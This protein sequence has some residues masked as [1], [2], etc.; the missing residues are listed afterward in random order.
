MGSL[1]AG[2]VQTAWALPQVGRSATKCSRRS[3]KHGLGPLVQKR[4]YI[5][6]Y[7]D[8]GN[9]VGARLTPARRRHTLRERDRKMGSAQR[10]VLASGL[11]CGLWHGLCQTGSTQSAPDATLYEKFRSEERRV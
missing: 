5:G 11:I 3:P 8:F 10:L 4:H 6:H 9:A 1:H 7:V 2:Q